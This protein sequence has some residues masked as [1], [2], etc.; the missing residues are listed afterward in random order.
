MKPAAASK[1]AVDMKPGLLR[2]AVTIQITKAAEN[3][4]EEANP[5][6]NDMMPPRGKTTSKPKADVACKDTVL[7]NLTVSTRLDDPYVDKEKL[8][9]FL[10]KAFGKGHYRVNVN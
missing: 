9:A 7:P 6:I 4:S 8:K 1:P 3:P 5:L 10:V 2:K